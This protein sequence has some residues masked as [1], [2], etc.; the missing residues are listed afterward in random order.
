MRV[1]LA[2]QLL[3]ALHML[4]EYVFAWRV[5]ILIPIRATIGPGFVIHTWGGGIVLPACPIG[6]DVTMIGG[7]VQ[8]DYHTISIGDRCEFAPGT[9]G[10]GKIR[11]G[12]RVK[13][14]PNS[15][16][17]TDVPDDSIAFGNPARIVPA[18]KWTFAPTGAARARAAAAPAPPAP[19][20][21]SD[22]TRT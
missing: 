14:G 4:V 18:R 15:V 5:G 17:Q 12:D 7:G 13:T 11:I 22:R 10:V 2:R 9:K 6:R 20:A 3:I 19:G 16:I 8:F 1:P 21:T